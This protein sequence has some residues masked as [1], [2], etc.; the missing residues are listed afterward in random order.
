MDRAP[1][2]QNVKL[3]AEVEPFIPQKKNLDAFV[4]PMAL[5]TDNGSVSGVEPTPIPSYLITCYPF[6]Q[7]N[8]SNRQFP[9]YNND[10][11]WQQ[12]SPS[13]TG[14]YLAYPIL[15]A[16]PPV[17]TEYTYYQLMP[18][19]CAQ[20]MGFYH[21][22]PTPYS[23]TFQAANTVNAITTECTERPNQLGQPFPLSSHRSRNGNRG[24][25]VPKPQLLQQHI[26]NSDLFQLT[27]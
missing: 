10:I 3:S 16:Q 17:S 26:K 8:Q 14:P 1:A 2:E 20:V 7:E 24:P 13:P 27:L 19:P 15:S 12:P 4:L 21:P 23:S 5:P 18:A 9:L 25:V 22:F 11:R 6:V